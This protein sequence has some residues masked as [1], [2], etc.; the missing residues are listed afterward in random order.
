MTEPYR[1]NLSDRDSFSQSCGG[2][3]TSIAAATVPTIQKT[4]KRISNKHAVLPHLS[5]SMLSS[6]STVLAFQAGRDYFQIE[7]F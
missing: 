3:T 7:D 5:D 4:I 6:S 1:E 2:V